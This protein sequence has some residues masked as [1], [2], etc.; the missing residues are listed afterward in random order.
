MTYFFPSPFTSDEKELTQKNALAYTIN[1]G[2]N[3]LRLTLKSFQL[4]SNARIGIPS[5]CCKA[6]QISVIE[7]GFVPCFFD[8][9]EEQSYWA[10]YNKDQILANNIKA[11]MLVHLYGFIHPDSKEIIEFCHKNNIKV[12]HDAAQSFGIDLSLL[13][14]DPI[15]Y[16]FGPGKSTTA[17]LGG[18]IV[19][20]KHFSESVIGSPKLIQKIKARIFFNSRLIHFKHQKI[21]AFFSYIFNSFDSEDHSFF[22][23][24][25]FQKNKA[26]TVKEL[27]IRSKN[28]RKERYSILVSSICN[29]QNIIPAYD[30]GNGF[31]FKLILYVSKN[32]DNFIVY[33]DKSNI[34][35]YRL[36]K[37]IDLQKRM[38]E[39]LPKFY[40]SYLNFVEI[41]TE[42]SIPMEE[43]RRVAHALSNFK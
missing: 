29:N 18:E 2:K 9:K 43:I 35:Y 40:S 38:E 42:R 34:P 14:D 25:A 31:Y 12:I 26:L 27:V 3:A 15:I 6:V 23:M 36:A 13:K 19:N 28:E 41:S 5:F 33:L 8:L 37:D 17:A 10:D 1:S 21:N 39:V 11:I 7:E 30:D 4:P 20:L 24:S 32:V 16:S 22:S